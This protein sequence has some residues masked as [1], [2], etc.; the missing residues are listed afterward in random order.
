MSR[1]TVPRTSSRPTSSRPTSSRLAEPSAA[2]AGRGS[3]SVANRRTQADQSA[4]AVRTSPPVPPAPSREPG[5]ASRAPGR[6]V[7]RRGRIDRAR[8]QASGGAAVVRRFERNARVV[9]LE[10]ARK[11]ARRPTRAMVIAAVTMLVILLAV[12]YVFL[13]SPWL[14]FTQVRLI[15]ADRFSQASLQ[16][17]TADVQGTPLARVDTSDL[18]AAIEKDAAVRTAKVVRAWPSTIEVRVSER[19]P[20]VAVPVD[21]KAADPTASSESTA[22]NEAGVDGR[23]G[24]A[25]SYQ[26][27]AADGVIVETVTELPAGMAVVTEPTIA[28]GDVAV[29][30]TAAVM[31]ALPTTLRRQ[32]V[33]IGATSRDNVL[34]TLSVP[35]L[36]EPATPKK[37]ETATVPTAVPTLGPAPL[38]KDGKPQLRTVTV[39]WGGVD[40]SALKAEVLGVLLATDAE[41]YDVSSPTTPVTRDSTVPKPTLSAAPEPGSDSSASASPPSAEP[42]P[43]APPT[44]APTGNAPADDAAGAAD[45]ATSVP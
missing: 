41:V 28:S 7:A 40:D 18:A 17:I 3:T 38:D 15:G 45:G 4:T 25:T 14:I 13:F 12:G 26:L 29:K 21:T 34:L 5:A 42:T 6:E 10:Q 9:S 44:S 32:V 20:V 37:G 19:V 39:V 23:K 43:T 24:S 27:M 8:A 35:A 33:D 30:A 22:E 36:A 1:P 2:R 11:V 31:D 16:A